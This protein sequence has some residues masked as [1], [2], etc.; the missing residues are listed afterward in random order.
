MKKIALLIVL[1]LSF[2]FTYA[3]NTSVLLSD[4]ANETSISFTLDDFSYHSVQ[5]QN[6]EEYVIKTQDGSS[7]LIQGAPDLQKLTAS[8]I[9]PDA[10]SSEIEVISSDYYEVENV[11]IAPSKG[12]FTRD[13]DP[14]SITFN[15]GDVYQRDEFF[16]GKLAD[17]NSPYIMRDLRGQVVNVYPF[18]YN[19]VT[20]TL[21]VY[22][23]ITVSVKYNNNQGVNELVRKKAFNTVSHEFNQIYLNHFINYNTNSSKYVPVEEEGNMLI[24]CYDDFMDEM[25]DFVVWKNTIGRPTEMVAVSTIGTTA[26][27]IATYVENYYNDNGLAYLLLVGDAA[28][29]PTNSGGGLG[30]D[31]DNAYAYILG[32][33]HYLDF[34]V[35]RFSAENADH[36]ITQ[37]QRTLTYEDG[38]TLED[39]W[40]NVPTGV[41]SSEGTGD[42]DE[43]DY[44]HARNILLQLTGDFTYTEPYY[45]IYDGSQGG[46]DEGGNATASQVSAALNTGTGI[47]NYTGHGD[48]TLWVSSHFDNDD[49]NNLTNDNK[50]PFIWSVACVNGAF[51][52]QTCFGEAWLRA[53]NGSNP[54]GAIGIMASTINQSWAPPMAAQDEMVDI[55]VESYN[56]N[57]KRSFAGLAINGCHLMNDEYSD[58]AMTDTW[59]CFGDPSLLVRTDDAVDMTITHDDV[60]VI[61]ATTFD[62]N[63]DLDG[64]L[65]T[66]SMNGQIVGTA[67]VTGGVASVPVVGVNPGDVLTLAV[68][69]FN[70]VTYLTDLMVIAPSG[71]YIVLTDANIAGVQSLDYASTGNIDI[72]LTNVGPEVA[73]AVSVD[74]YSSDMYVQNFVNNTNVDFGNITGDNGTS[75]ST[76]SFAVTLTNNVPDQH[77]VTF[78]VTV[79]DLNDS[80]WYS[81]FAITANSPVLQ[82]SF[83]GV[84]DAADQIAFASS[85]ITAVETNSAYSY[86]VEISELGGNDNGNLDP[87][88][89]VVITF[90]AENIGHAGIF[91]AYGYLTTTS[92]DVTINNPETYVES[93]EVGGSFVSD[94]NIEVSPDAVIG[95]TVDFQFIV[96]DGEYND[97]LNYT[98]PIGLIVE[99]FESGDLNSYNWVSDGWTTTNT[100]AYEGSYAVQ[101]NDPGDYGT[102]TLEIQLDNVP[103]GQNMSFYYKVSTED[104][105]DYFNV[106]VDGS[107]VLE[108]SGEE[109]WTLFEYTFTSAGD[110]AISFDYTR[111]C[112]VSGGSDN[113]WLDYVVFPVAPAKTKSPLSISIDASTIPGWLTLVDN[114]DGTAVLSGTS[115]AAQQI[116]D[117]VL[118]ATD[119]TNTI[120]QDFS[121][122]V[123]SAGIANLANTVSV[124][125][126]PAQ[127]FVNV[128]LGNYTNATIEISDV[129][130][131]IVLG[132]TLNASDNTVDVS[133]LASGIYFVQISVGNE[134]IQSKLIKK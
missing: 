110:Y 55:L 77:V 86:Y 124:F 49:I 101:S 70:K 96:G 1:A 50:L 42:D 31:S 64:A 78:D 30:G 15:Y 108:I 100:G 40:L 119:G 6:G 3:Q 24:I 11:S 126:N 53:T 32:S 9:I 41:A 27:S 57:I 48:V 123:G 52:G 115:P 7:L 4:N 95:T 80:V 107:S 109:D 99:D 88:E 12:N 56:D 62:V 36:V 90:S 16:P 18:Q 85:P 65:A 5:T 103:A 28:Q 133:Q 129:N 120:T 81:Q 8:I 116:D 2:S 91:D 58:F 84:N 33:D 112:C 131:R 102:N 72:T 39:G 54:T 76:G 69:G 67:Y 97:T 73:N 35:G 19:P 26:S 117:V 13:I 23:E 71:P 83:D 22:T 132:S 122:N 10:G 105:Y 37:V 79:T 68:I 34:F 111:D 45:E 14:S 128:S 98:L 66:L 114:G 21:R 106:F 89:N 20:K 25:E 44:E 43:Y 87:G 47:I 134:T 51:D 92:T 46:Y 59:T 82:G 93:I 61:G 127:N 63:C 17:I 130:G 75:T 38:S 74:V 104:G 125:P 121:V 118:T 94:F 60:I 113:V 29:I